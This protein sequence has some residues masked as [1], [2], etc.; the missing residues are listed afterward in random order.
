MM[1]ENGEI[2]GCERL[3]GTECGDE[4]TASQ[5][6]LQ[7]RGKP[8]PMSYGT[9]ETACS[10][11]PTVELMYQRKVIMIVI[12]SFTVAVLLLAYLGLNGG[13]KED[14]QLETEITLN[15]VKGLEETKF[16]LEEIVHYLRDHVQCTRLGGKLPKGILL[17]GPAGT[18]KK[19]LYLELLQE[20]LV[21]HFLQEDLSA[22][23]D[24]RRV[25]KLF[26]A[27]KKQSPCVIFIDNIDEVAGCNLN[28][29]LVELDSFKQNNG[30]IVIGSTKFP[31][32]VD[33]AL[34]RPG[35]LDRHIVVPK[36][37]LEGRIKILESYMSMSEE[38]KLGMSTLNGIHRN[39]GPLMIASKDG[40]KEVSMAHLKYA[41]DEMIRSAEA[42]NYY[43]QTVMDENQKRKT[44]VYDSDSSMRR[45]QYMT[46]EQTLPV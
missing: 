32:Q 18:G 8:P 20:K 29:L 22:I 44:R 28:Q 16:E 43:I 41:V 40:A 4:G 26:K 36:P 19:M 14:F 37:D 42:W 31:L 21:F 9:L 46:Y 39:L 25:R 27:A 17:V 33:K 5:S 23:D 12:C 7:N 2:P 11:T 38:F 1:L 3:N 45:P 30:I 34:V 6:V 13:D 24:P 35:R 15:D 10:P